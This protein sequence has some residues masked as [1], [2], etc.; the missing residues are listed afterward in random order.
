[1]I[2]GLEG[3]PGSGKSYEAVAFHVLPALKAGRKVIT[4]LPL[5]LDALAAIDPSY[6]DL[7]EVRTRPTPQLGDWNAAHIAEQEAFQLWTDK[8]PIPQSENVFTFGTVW[9]YYSDWRG[10]KNQGPL[11]V[12][13]ECHVAL[14]KLGTPEGVVQWF[15]LHRHY[16][17]DVLLMTQS[18]RDI[19][20][21]IAQLIA[22]LIK[23]R[24]ADILGKKASYIRKVHAGYR[25]AVIQTD[26]RK[27]ESQYF[28]LYR[29]NTQSSGSAESGVTDVNPMIVKFNRFKWVFWAFA[30]LFTVWAFWPDG[31][32]DVW[33]RKKA[34]PEPAKA[35]GI[36]VV[37][38]MPL[39]KAI[40]EGKVV[41]PKPV[42]AAVEKPAVQS[43]QAEDSPPVAK[44]PLFG[45]QLHV[46]GDLSKKG[47]S[48]MLFIVSDGSRRM[49]EVTSEDLQDA[50]Y[51]VKRLATCMVT[52]KFE[53]VVRPVTCDAP[54]LNTGGQDR[55]LVIDAATGG[56]SDGR[57]TR[58]NN[59]PIPQEVAQARQEQQ[60]QAGGYLEAL[61]R[62]NS[63]VRSVLMDN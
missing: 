2:N 38:G 60:Q 4:N 1:M 59:A 55:P 22:T 13:D 25:G 3:I 33:G 32:R 40:A 58:Y 47:K 8:E 61:A 11:Y 44:D 41:P 52:V 29:S 24:K 50:G 16:N 26:E 34:V 5:N 45:K 56:R 43:G 54:Y 48:V 10:S 57:N 37:S 15:K 7:V 23:C 19:N 63:Q 36:P 27:Y 30:L 6:R 12:I 39:S 20:Q 46:A 17:A 28:G 9:D 49:F 62:R 18:F 21:P 53:G 51:S 42:E 31:E 14:P 35:S